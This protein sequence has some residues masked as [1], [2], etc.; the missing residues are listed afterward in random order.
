MKRHARILRDAMIAAAAMLS[1]AASSPAQR[2]PV[3]QR[4]P[5]PGPAPVADSVRI[6]LLTMG[7]GTEVY[8]LFG[9]NAIWVHEPDVHPDLVYNWGVFDFNTPGFIPRFLL[10][11]MRYTMDF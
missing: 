10:G 3:L 7:Q 4:A 11:D 2:Q 6:T 1:I 9:H 8:E 5:A